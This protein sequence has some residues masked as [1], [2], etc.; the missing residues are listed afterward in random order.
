MIFKV[1]GNLVFKLFWLV[2]LRF[3]SCRCR[4]HQLH[5]HDQEEVH[6]RTAVAG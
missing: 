4:E 6:G 5:W 3:F 1:L 2:T